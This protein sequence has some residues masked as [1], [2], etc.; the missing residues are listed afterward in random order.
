MHFLGEDA[1]WWLISENRRGGRNS[2]TGMKSIWRKLKAW[3]LSTMQLTLKKSDQ[4]NPSW[5]VHVFIVQ[6][7]T[8][9]SSWRPGF[10]QLGGEGIRD[11]EGPV[12]QLPLSAMSMMLGPRQRATTVCQR[13]TLTCK[14]GPG[15]LWAYV[16]VGEMDRCKNSYHTIRYMIFVS[17]LYPISRT[18]LRGEP[19]WVG[20][21]EGFVQEVALELNLWVPQAAKARAICHNTSCPPGS[22]PF[23]FHTENQL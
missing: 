8:E 12:T 9:Q 13:R 14:M 17:M 16:T 3:V 15:L 4:K 19:L 22:L 11:F 5:D 6:V 23:H 1:L 2:N 20:P 21:A 18:E 10:R 7:L